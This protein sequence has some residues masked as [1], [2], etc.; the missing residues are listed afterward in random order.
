MPKSLQSWVQSP[1]LPTQQN[2]RGGRCSSIEESTLKIQN[3]APKNMLKKNLKAKIFNFKV[4]YFLFS[5]PVV[6]RRAWTRGVQSSQLSRWGRSADSGQYAEIQIKR[7]EATQTFKRVRA[8]NVF[9]Y[10]YLYTWPPNW[11]VSIYQ[12]WKIMVDWLD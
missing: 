12:A 2:L 5:C 9:F 7:T 4:M 6:S 8:L 11:N 10:K 3:L 1:Q